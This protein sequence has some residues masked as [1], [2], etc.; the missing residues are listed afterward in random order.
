MFTLNPV[1]VIHLGGWYSKITYGVLYGANA[2]CGRPND[3]IITNLGP[4]AS[5]R[6]DNVVWNF[7]YQ[8]VRDV[9]AT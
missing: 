1:Q 4:I 8:S 9:I 2:D 7:K 6:S 5:V 3:Y